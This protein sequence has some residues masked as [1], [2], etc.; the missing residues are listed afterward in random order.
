MTFLH[1]DRIAEVGVVVAAMVIVI[2][3]V[4]VVIAAMQWWCFENPIYDLWT[5]SLVYGT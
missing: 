2:T 1:S 4:E 5:G 3:S